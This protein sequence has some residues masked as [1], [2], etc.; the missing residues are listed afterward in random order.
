MFFSYEPNKKMWIWWG[1]HFQLAIYSLSFIW[2]ILILKSSDKLMA[3]LIQT[4]LTS[5][6]QDFGNKCLERSPLWNLHSHLS[7]FIKQQL[8]SDQSLTWHLLSQ[9]LGFQLKHGEDV[10]TSVG[11]QL[12]RRGTKADKKLNQNPCTQLYFIL[13]L[14]FHLGT[15]SKIS[16]AS[17]PP[18][19]LT[20]LISH[21]L[22]L[23]QTHKRNQNVLLLTL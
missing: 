19:W 2:K 14:L 15:G 20:R 12:R 3:L 10:G 1:N 16:H 4:D 22:S 17:F 18:V 7:V 23:T 8:I 21:F 11:R 5:F 6:S 9:A 13:C